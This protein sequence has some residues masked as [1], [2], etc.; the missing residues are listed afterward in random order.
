MIIS[1][2]NIS[3]MIEKIKQDIVENF[4]ESVDYYSFSYIIGSKYIKIVKTNGTSKSAYCFVEISTGNILKSAN[5]K[6]PAKGTRGNIKS[7][8]DITF[9]PYGSCFYKQ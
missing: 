8:N 9:D 2:G 1:T 5:W 3:T 7:L 6:T 4:P